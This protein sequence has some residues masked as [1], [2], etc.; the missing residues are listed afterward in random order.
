MV[1]LSIEYEYEVI[2]S[3]HEKHQGVVYKAGSSIEPGL[4]YVKEHKKPCLFGPYSD[5]LT[6]M[7]GPSTSKF[8]DAMTLMYLLPILK[9]GVVIGT[10]CGRV[11]NDVL[12]D[13]IQRES[14]HVYPDSGDNYIFMAKPGLNQ[15]I[16]V[17]TALSR[18]RFEDLTFTHGENLKDGV[19]TDWGTVSVKEHTE[20][21]LIFTDPATNELHP[22][23][24]NTIR[25]GN[26]LFVEFPGYSD[27]RHISVI[28]KGVTFQLPHCPDQWGMMCEGDLDEVYRIRSINWKMKR[29]Q[30][31]Y[32]LGF[33]AL[34]LG[35]I[36]A[37]DIA[38]MLGIMAIITHLLYSAFVI[39]RTYSVGT[40]QT[41]NQLNRI[42]Q[43]IRM[44]AEGKV[45]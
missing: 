2:C 12:G 21:E 14:G 34:M 30:F 32:S 18:S 20:L 27:Y 40:R 22:G 35:V 36:L 42:N 38:P 1:V 15:H 26:N 16:Q 24:A 37:S 45:I 23:V 31:G 44:N 39:R 8:H 19:R 7:I 43:F 29:A 41:V 6:S 28:G 3:T 4:N 11:P 9:D 13:L 10:L 25:N 5:K 33:F 17:G